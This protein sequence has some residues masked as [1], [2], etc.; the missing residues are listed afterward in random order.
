MQRI[1]PPQSVRPSAVPPPRPLRRQLSPYVWMLLI[2]SGIGLAL[3]VVVGLIVVMLVGSVFLSPNILPNVAVAGSAI[4]SVPVGGLSTDE[5]VAKLQAAPVDRTITLRDQARIWEISSADLGIA[6]DSAATAQAA[7]D[8]GRSNLGTGISTM[9]SG[10]QVAPIYTI[11]LAK[12]Q[13]ALT[14]LSGKVNIE[15]S[16]T[17]VTAS[18]RRLNVGATI[19]KFPSDLGVLLEQGTLDLVMDVVEGPRTKYTV[20]R[21]EELAIIAKKFNV[22]ITDIVKLNNLSNPDQI[23][24]GQVLI[25][26]APGVWV[27]TQK[28]APP[29]PLAKGKSIVVALDNQRIY[30]YEDGKLVHSSLMSSGLPETETVKGDFKVYVKYVTTRM[31]GP[32]YDIPDVPWTMYFYQGYG[33]HGAYWHNTFGRVRSHGCVNLDTDE[34]KWF[35]DFAPIG[36]LVRVIKTF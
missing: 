16:S 2:G 33:I 20:E 36:T 6:L 23:Y 8:A 19:D 13:T 27:P 31:R 12:A 11:D 21:G 15:P 3:L 5:A 9:I 22:S 34:A 4:T 7:A 26:P 24:P 30:A 17:D 14:N 32:D 1:G 10:A 18:G 28:D 35:Y 25:I 29:A